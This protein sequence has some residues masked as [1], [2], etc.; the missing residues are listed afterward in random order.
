[1]SE[2]PPPPPPLGKKTPGSTTELDSNGYITVVLGG[3][4]EEGGRKKKSCM[5]CEQR[6]KQNS[7][8]NCDSDNEK[9]S[10]KEKYFTGKR[11]K[12]TWFYI[13]KKAMNF[14]YKCIISENKSY[15][16]VYD[17]IWT[18]KGCKKEIWNIDGPLQ[19]T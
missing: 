18:L 13:I 2:S 12:E 7:N 19:M 9:Y 16:T 8:V 15:F 11:R 6:N 14:F 10:K 4:G 3:G 1:M 5:R 17:W